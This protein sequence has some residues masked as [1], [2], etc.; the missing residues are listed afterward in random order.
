M[1]VLFQAVDPVSVAVVSL[2]SSKD[3][4]FEGGPRPWVLEP[5]KF[6]CDMAAEDKAGVSLALTNPSSHKYDQHWLRATCRSLGEQVDFPFFFFLNPFLPLINSY[7]VPWFSP[8][9]FFF[10]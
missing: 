3:M 10:L 7:L 5:S 4:L 1:S 6:F 2:G 8:F 9:F